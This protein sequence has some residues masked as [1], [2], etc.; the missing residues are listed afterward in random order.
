[1]PS[2]ISKERTSVR[3]ES[4]ST[5]RIAIVVA[6]YGRPELI[7]QLLKT[8]ETQTRRPDEVVFSIT[9]E[10]SDMPAIYAT[11]LNVTLLT[12]RPGACAQRNTALAHLRGRVDLILFIDDDFW[13]Y[14]TYVEELERIFK[15]DGDVVAATGRVLADG[16]TSPGIS[17]NSAEQLLDQYA[18]EANLAETIKDVPS[19]YGCNMAFRADTVGDTRFDERLPLYGWQEDVDFSARLKRKG[20]IVWSNRLC[21]VHLG[22]KRGK[23]S[24]LRFGYSQVINPLYILGK[25]NMTYAKALTLITKNILANAAKSIFSEPYIDRR[26][27]LKGNLIGLFHAVQGKLD[28]MAVL[29]L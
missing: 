2:V 28:P 5:M 8:L 17:I 24:G 22:S 29:N 23:I 21:G 12:G 6:S 16:A 11:E 20:R 27:R 3:V 25:G 7:E 1:L 4:L 10:R 15:A 9:N 26:G 14:K 18:S 13:M 19:T